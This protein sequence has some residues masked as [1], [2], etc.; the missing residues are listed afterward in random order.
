MSTLHMNRETEIT[1][2]FKAFTIEIVRIPSYS[3]WTL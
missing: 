2:A 1:D 3:F